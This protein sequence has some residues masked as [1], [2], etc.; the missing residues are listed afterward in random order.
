MGIQTRN[1]R[2]IAYGCCCCVAA[3]LVGFC[4]QAA[5]TPITPTTSESGLSMAME[6]AWRLSPLAAGLD[7][8]EGE[9]RAAQ[10]IAA[11]LTPEP[12]S[13]S[14]GSLSDQFSRNQGKQEFEVE[15]AVPLWLPGQK[16]L[17]AA[18]A[19]SR[20]NEAVTRRAAAPS[21]NC[22]AAS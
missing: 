16:A 18:E 7:A 15:L 8:R 4:V 11:G 10:D 21:T 13:V 20:I 17:R 9:A 14:I 5:E 19:D 3:L 22:S 12:G 2:R 1:H 6:Q